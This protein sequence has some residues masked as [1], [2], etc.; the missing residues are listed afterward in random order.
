MLNFSCKTLFYKTIFHHWCKKKHLKT[1]LSVNPKFSSAVQSNNI[2]I[3]FLLTQFFKWNYLFCRKKL[4]Y[5]HLQVYMSILQI[6]KISIKSKSIFFRNI[7]VFYRLFYLLFQIQSRFFLFLYRLEYF[8]SHLRIKCF[9][10]RF[11]GSYYD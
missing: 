1:F 6:W 10:L 2:P 7:N 9:L 4:D 5:Y 3:S 8:D 11:D